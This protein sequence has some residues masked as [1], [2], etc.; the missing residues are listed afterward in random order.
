MAAPAEAR[1]V[2]TPGQSGNPFSEH[3]GDLAVR[4][5]DFTWFTFAA[6]PRGA[7]LTLRPAP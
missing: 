3:Y 4:W 1:F 2:I 6:A 5:R 7:R